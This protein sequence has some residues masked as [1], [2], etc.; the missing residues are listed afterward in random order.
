MRIEGEVEF[1]PESA[2]EQF[3]QARPFDDKVRTLMY[4]S[5]P[6]SSKVPSVHYL[7][8][9]YKELVQKYSGDKEI[10]FKSGILSGYRIIPSL[11]EFWQGRSNPPLAIRTQFTRDEHSGK[12]LSAILVP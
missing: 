4:E 3:F 12:W 1:L 7:D 8:E 6:L 9:K 10:P 11:F 2:A 5:L